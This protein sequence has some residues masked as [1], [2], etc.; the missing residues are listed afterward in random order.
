MAGGGAGAGA[1][2][3]AGGFVCEKNR[4]LARVGT[5]A[6]L[7]ANGAP[8]CAG[9]RPLLRPAVAR[10]GH[11]GRQPGPSTLRG[12]ICARA[13]GLGY[14]AAQLLSPGSSSDSRRVAPRLCESA[15]RLCVCLRTR[16]TALGSPGCF[17]HILFDTP[18]PAGSFQGSLWVPLT[19]LP[20]LAC[21]L[22]CTSLKWSLFLSFHGAPLPNKDYGLNE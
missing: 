11:R 6:S 20:P 2:S 21:L 22:L 19:P 9:R 18:S 13:E 10:T 17:S 16:C 5:L 15:A 12:S 14:L 8:L 3:Q 7:N 1:G 4:G